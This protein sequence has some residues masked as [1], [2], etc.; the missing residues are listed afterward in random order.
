MKSW[1]RP[2]SSPPLPD[3][4][5]GGLKDLPAGGGAP[6]ASEG[7]GGAIVDAHVH[8][9]PPEL[10]RDRASFLDRDPWFAS[11]YASPGATMATAEDVVAAMDADGVGTA[12]VFGFAFRDQGL[13]RLTN[14]YVLEAVKTHPGRI[15]GLCCVSPEMP[16]AVAELE[17]C[18]DAGLR[19]CGEL[20][21]D[22]QGFAAQWI[23]AAG[24]GAGG[25]RAVP[26]APRQ[27]QGP[28]L[29]PGSR[30]W[31]PVWL[32]RDL[33]LLIHSN[34]PVGHGYAGKGR[35]TPEACFAFASAHPDLT[36]VFAHM[37]GGLFLYELMPEVRQALA[38]VY[39][40]TTA[41]PYLYGPEVY[42][43]AVACAGAGK[44]L[45]G[46]DFPL[47]P[48]RRYREGLGRLDAVSQAA[49][50]GENARKVFRL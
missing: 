41:V 40:D 26:P 45:F 27:D 21:P 32:E 18:L 15:V 17:R 33:P 36:I 34:E 25:A 35:F 50:L 4:V 24:G 49:V 30:T 31:P 29:D 1:W 42:E 44:F 10:I 47:L 23:G 13:C 28:T 39:Y 9:F 37:G 14:D 48:P 20:A 43:V 46:S 6:D 3:P 5:A 8:V 38:R 11:L 2:S 19:G 22:G 16:G 7:S 12:V